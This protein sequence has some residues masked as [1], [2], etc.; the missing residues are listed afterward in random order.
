MTDVT[1]S[2]GCMVNLGG[3]NVNLGKI[4]T[5]TSGSITD[6]S[7]LEPGDMDIAY[8]SKLNSTLVDSSLT[9]IL[10]L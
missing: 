10:N 9:T 4:S 5:G 8:L 7:C 1:R 3:F 2:Q 6:M